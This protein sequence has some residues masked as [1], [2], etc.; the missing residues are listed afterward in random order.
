LQHDV[1]VRIVKRISRSDAVKKR[2]SAGRRDRIEA[3]VDLQVQ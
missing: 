3:G 1:E 2:C